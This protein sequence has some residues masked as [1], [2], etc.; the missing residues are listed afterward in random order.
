VGWDELFS[1]KKIWERRLERRGGRGFALV[2]LNFFYDSR[3][4]NR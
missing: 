3:K 4:K 2:L 1:I